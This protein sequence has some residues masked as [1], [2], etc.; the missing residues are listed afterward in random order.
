[1]AVMNRPA[2]DVL[3]HLLRSEG[4]FDY[5]DEAVCQNEIEHFLRS[6]KVTFCR[7]YA[8]SG[9]DICDFYFPKSKIVMEVKAGKSWGKRRVYRQC[10]RYCQHDAVNGLV[11]ATG[12][13]QGMPISIC[14]KPIRVYQLGIGFL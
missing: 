13:I 14:N 6:K 5:A 7:G 3:Y 8:L 1:M 4:R 2:I 12:S 11:L 10:E 9:S